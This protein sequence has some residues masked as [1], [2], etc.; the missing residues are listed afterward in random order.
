MKS[1]QRLACLRAEIEHAAQQ[2][3]IAPGKHP[4][5]TRGRSAHGAPISGRAPSANRISRRRR[6]STARNEDQRLRSVGRVELRRGRHSRGDLVE[7][8]SDVPRPHTCAND[9]DQGK[10]R[11]AAAGMES[12]LGWIVRFRRRLPN[13]IA[14]GTKVVPQATSVRMDMWLTNGTRETLSDLRVQNCVML[15]GLP[16]FTEQSNDNKTF[17]APMPCADRL[18][19]AAGSSRR[20]ILAI[21]RGATTNALAYIPIPNSPTALRAE[22]NVS[23]AGCRSTRGRRSTRS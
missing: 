8:G 11:L 16:G 9:L 15:K 6:S 21:A 19:V 17:K 7:P 22:P 18:T 10:Y 23:E 1:P 3:N 4:P 2:F 12:T 20:G 5:R 14:F 13:G